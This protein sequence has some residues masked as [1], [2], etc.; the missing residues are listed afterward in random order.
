MNGADCIVFTAG[1]GEHDAYVRKCVAEGLE[2]MGVSID[3]EKNNNVGKGITDITGKDGKVRILVIP[4][5]EELVIARD[6]AELAAA[7][8]K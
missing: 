2:Y 1:I 8:R 6:T 7:A 5:N 3:E 4:T